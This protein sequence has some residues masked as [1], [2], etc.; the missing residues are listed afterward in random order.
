M[1]TN[2]KAIT[3]VMPSTQPSRLPTRA[4]SSTHLVSAQFSIP[5]LPMMAMRM[6][7]R[8]ILASKVMPRPIKALV[9][10]F[11]PEATLPVSPPEKI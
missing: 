3:P 8:I 4:V 5:L 1:T 11:L 6:E 7:L 9:R 2:A 10:V